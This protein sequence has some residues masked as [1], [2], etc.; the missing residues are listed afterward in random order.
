MVICLLSIGLA[1]ASASAETLLD[2]GLISVT[3]VGSE[4][5]EFG[6]VEVVINGAG[7]T[8]GE[9]SAAMPGAWGAGNHPWVTN[10]VYGFN[11]GN[12]CMSYAMFTFDQE[13]QLEALKV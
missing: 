1:V 9:H 11:E 5:W 4:W 3:A 6:P 10:T 12:G 8:A 13:H 2:P 7:L